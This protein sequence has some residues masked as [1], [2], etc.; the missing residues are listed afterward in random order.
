MHRSILGLASGLCLVGLLVPPGWAAPSAGAAGS[1]IY[2][3][4]PLRFEPVD[5][6]N[7][8][9]H[10]PG[11]GI[12]LN[13]HGA[14][15]QLGKRGLKLSFEG[16]ARGSTFEGVHKSAAPSNYFGPDARTVDAFSRLRQKNVYPG[17]DVLY[18]GKGRSIEYDFELAPGTDPA[19]IRMRF[20]GADSVRIGPRGDLILALGD[21]DIVQNAPV[22]YQRHAP[23]QVVAVFSS[24]VPREN[25]SFGIELGDYDE[26]LPLIVDPTILFTAYLAGTSADVPIGIGHDK[27]GSIYIAGYT[28]SPD[29]ALVGTAYTGFF[30]GT[31]QQAFTTVMNPLG[32]PEDVITYSG[33]FSGDFGDFL[34]AMA[35]DS[36]GV[37]YLAGV[38]DDFNFPVTPSGYLT[39]NGGVRRSFISVIDTKLPGK[40]GLTYST[41]FAGTKT[42]EPTAI[43][44]ARGKIYVTGFTTSDDYPVTANAYQSARPGGSSDGWVAEFDP[45]QSGSASLVASTLLGGAGQDLPR[46]IAV[47]PDGQAYVA[48]YTRSVDYPTT[49]NSFR[50]F[51]SGSGDAFLTRINLSAMTLTYSTFL[52]GSGQDQATK[53]LVDPLNRVALTGFTLSNDFPVTPNALQSTQAGNGDVFL[54][55]LDPAAPDFTKALVYSTYFGGTDGDVAYDFRLDA[56]GKYYLCGYTLSLDLPVVN[57]IA[58]E[59]H[60]GNSLDGFVAVIDPAAPPLQALIYSSHVTGPGYQVAYGID[61]DGRGN[62]YVTGA[63]LGDVFGG[64]GAKAPPDSSLNVFLLVFRLDDNAGQDQLRRNR[65]GRAQR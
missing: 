47:A 34:K 6:H 42:D 36:E 45:S 2:A 28:Y 20:E 13:Q 12:A 39:N 22:V 5:S 48:G 57:A 32:P 1:D 29:F 43:A 10:G 26:R 54:T 14:F 52:G 65:V 19:Q 38:T 59:T 62:I 8:V 30:L 21:R 64:M 63:V 51:Y 9:G 49:P 4:I 58:P 7:W 3:S 11:F 17:I 40:S 46:S 53:I 35:V 44:V 24:Y 25:G 33:F 56:S 31:G 15:L 23:D 37:F 55:V 16:R 61:V 41:F 50:P 27:N 60:P 18:Y